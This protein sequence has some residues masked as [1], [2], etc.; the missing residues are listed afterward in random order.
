MS[1]RTSKSDHETHKQYSPGITATSAMKMNWNFWSKHTYR[2]F[3]CVRVFVFVCVYKTCIYIHTHMHTHTHTYTYT[4]IHIQIHLHIYIHPSIHTYIHTYIHIHS[5]IDT[6]K[7][8]YLTR[9][10][11]APSL[12]YTIIVHSAA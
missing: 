9:E 5:D 10:H 12:A 4:Y 7:C 8:I 3:V 1:F 2:V 11:T 6:Y